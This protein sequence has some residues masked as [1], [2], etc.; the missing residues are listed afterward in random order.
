MKRVL[1]VAVV[2]LRAKGYDLLTVRE[3]LQLR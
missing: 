3:I 2:G 1:I